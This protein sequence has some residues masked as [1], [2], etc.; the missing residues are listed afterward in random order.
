MTFSSASRAPSRAASPPAACTARGFTN[1]HSHHESWLTDAGDGQGLACT[2][3]E[4]GSSGR[5]AS[6]KQSTTNGVQ[7]TWRFIS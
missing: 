5:A 6:A 4:S 2:A 7:P 3:S 1:H